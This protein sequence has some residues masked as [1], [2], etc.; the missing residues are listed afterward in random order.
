MEKVVS[1]G[2]KID[3]HIHSSKSKFKDDG[4]VSGGTIANINILIDKLNKNQVNVCSVSDH[5][6]FDYAIYSKLKEEEGKGS[7]VKV[8]PA[9]EFT[10]S[11]TENELN[12]VHVVCVFDD[13]NDEKIK[14]IEDV[15]KF[16]EETDRPKYDKEDSFSENR[17]IELLSQIDID[18]VCIAH[19]KK[20]LTSKD[21]PQKNDAN[22]VGEE[23]FN[24]FLFSEYFEAFEFKNRKNQAFNNYSQSKLDG[25]LLRFITGSDCHEW[26]A[27][28]KYSKKS[29]DN[30]FK[31]TYLKCLPNFKGLALSLTDYTRISLDDNFYNHNKRYLDN[32]SIKINNDDILIPLSKGINVI[33]GDNSI[34]KSLLLH[35]MTDYYRVDALSPLN[36]TIKK[37]YE[38]YLEQNNIYITTTINNRDIFAF[39]TQGEIRKKFNQDK[40]KRDVFFKDKYPPDIDTSSIKAKIVNEIDAYLQSLKQKFNYD[41]IYNSF[42]DLKLMSEKEDATSISVID[43]SSKELTD[44]RENNTKIIAQ[45]SKTISE[46]Q[47]LLNILSS[48]E[49]VKVL[50]FLE[51]L[52]NLKIKYE[53]L[54]TKTNEKLSLTNCI[55]SA[56]SEYKSMKDRVKTTMDKN[57]EDYIQQK[58]I[59]IDSMISLLEAKTKIKNINVDIEE[60]EIEDEKLDYLKFTFIKRTKVQKINNE[61]LINLLN[62]PLKKN[63]NN[64]YDLIDSKNK[65]IEFLKDFDD[66]E[67]LD[68]YKNKLIEKIDSDLSQRAIPNKLD[69]KGK[70]VEYSSGLNSQIYFE[71]LSA[72]RYKDGI[73]I[74]DQPEDDVSPKSI[75]KHLLGNF[76]DMGRNRQ[77]LMVTHNPQFVVNLDVD[78]VIVITKDEDKIVVES[79]ALEYQDSK[80]NILNKVASLLDG[81]VETIRRRWKRYEKGNKNN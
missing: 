24:E 61:Y 39:D 79:G 48:E 18:V 76:K 5:D 22:V 80:T 13:T 77:I 57:L 10:V 28:P 53:N 36:E 47:L 58:T 3:L 63:K 4:V 32:I 56:F 75:K 62:Y 25:D 11:F 59:F 74:I 26:E 16:D 43:C 23:K 37:G 8:F 2:L 12:V 9:V 42:A 19:Q 71:I 50:E 14:K 78:N 49:N 40:L 15:L 41:E 17:F 52:K 67:P 33:I 34:G 65:L 45:L 64:K 55:N 54:K 27:Y 30:D 81:G 35:K 70:H 73:Y 38:S 51:Y 44:S 7:I 60:T 6:S 29:K 20:T 66:S 69:E 46:A 31:H 72:D 21:S 1:T 68:F